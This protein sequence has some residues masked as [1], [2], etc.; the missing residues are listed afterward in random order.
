MKLRAFNARRAVMY[1][2]HLTPI[3][4]A[5]LA[6]SDPWVHMEIQASDLYCKISFSATMAEGLDCA[7]FRDILYTHPEFWDTVEIPMTKREESIAWV[8][9]HEMEGTPYDKVGVLSQATDWDI[10]KP[11]PD[12]TWC[13]KTCARVICK[14]KPAFGEELVRLGYTD[15]YNIDPTDLMMLAMYW[16]GKKGSE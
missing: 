14:A 2:H 6:K 9:A 4:R 8:E 12:K 13:S 10:I 16:F 15:Q 11:D 7:R 1:G 5:I 3:Q